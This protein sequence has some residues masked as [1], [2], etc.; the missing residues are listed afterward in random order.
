MLHDLVLYPVDPASGRRGEELNLRIP[1]GLD[2]EQLLALWSEICRYMDTRQPLPPLPKLWGA[3]LRERGVPTDKAEQERAFA[4]IAAEWAFDQ[5]RAGLQAADLGIP[6][7]H[8]PA[9]PRCTH[10]HLRERLPAARAPTPPNCARRWRRW[11]CR[12]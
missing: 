12:R 11:G 1:P 9:H 5:R 8:D 4:E 10:P 6:P 3:V 7:E 2:G